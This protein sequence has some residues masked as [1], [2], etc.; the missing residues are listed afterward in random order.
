MDE[1][2]KFKTL[3]GYFNN[4]QRVDVGFDE[5]LRLPLP[6]SE[7]DD[8]GKTAFMVH[9]CIENIN[10]S[11]GSEEI[12]VTIGKPLDG[13]LAGPGCGLHVAALRRG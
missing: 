9:H 11:A 13:L 4:A 1:V 3:R 7:M 5:N 8:R 6:P 12:C 10:K 2:C